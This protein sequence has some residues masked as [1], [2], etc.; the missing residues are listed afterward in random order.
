M[1][2]PAKP[3]RPRPRN[4][5]RNC[6]GRSSCWAR[7]RSSRSGAAR[8][9]RVRDARPGSW[10]LAAEP[11]HDRSEGVDR[12][13]EHRDAIEP[14]GVASLLEDVADPIDITDEGMWMAKRFVG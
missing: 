9:R 8:G 7:H 1:P 3:P 13:L 2:M 5:P 4:G 14:K 12:V 10:L 11:V 6:G